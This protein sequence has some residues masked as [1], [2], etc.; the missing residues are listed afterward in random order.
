LR[1]GRNL[2]GSFDTGRRAVK[3]KFGIRS[4]LHASL[5]GLSSWDGRPGV[6]L[7]T[8]AERGTRSIPCAC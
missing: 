6:S 1:D 2:N 3:W 7:R 5:W 8:S 4:H